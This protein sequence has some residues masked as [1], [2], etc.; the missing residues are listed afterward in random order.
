MIVLSKASDEINHMVEAKK[1][2]KAIG[3]DSWLSVAASACNMV[4]TIRIRPTMP[5]K[6]WANAS[7]VFA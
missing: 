5:N 4:P 2:A 7:P 6:N 1:T 3:T